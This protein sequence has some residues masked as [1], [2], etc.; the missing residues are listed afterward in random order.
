MCA[1]LE[2]GFVVRA[3]ARYTPVRLDHGQLVLP[4]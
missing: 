4:R 2:T 3:I 1:C